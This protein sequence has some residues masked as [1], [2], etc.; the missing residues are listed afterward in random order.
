MADPPS[1]LSGW[2]HLWTTPKKT[3]EK[4]TTSQWSKWA[5]FFKAKTWQLVCTCL[6]GKMIRIRKIA[7]VC[8]FRIEKKEYFFDRAFIFKI[9]NFTDAVIVQKRQSWPELRRIQIWVTHY[10]LYGSFKKLQYLYSKN[11]QIMK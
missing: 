6:V 10:L 5:T 1:P 4:T 11:P 2:R 9:P 3:K 7:G 8:N